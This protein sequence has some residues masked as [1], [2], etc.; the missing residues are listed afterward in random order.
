MPKS[1][2]EEASK[3]LIEYYD[4]KRFK[5]MDDKESEIDIYIPVKPK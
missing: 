5:S 4:G 3:F 2:Y 1:N